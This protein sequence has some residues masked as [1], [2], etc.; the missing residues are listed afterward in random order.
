M[1]KFRP[2]KN[3]LLCGGRFFNQLRFLFFI[4]FALL[5]SILFFQVVFFNPHYNYAPLAVVCFAL[6]W[7]FV[8]FLLYRLTQ[9]FKNRIE[10]HEK[11]LL[12]GFG[13]L[14][15]LTQIFFYWQLAVYPTN[16]Y[17]RVFTGAVNFSVNGFI[18]EPYLDYFYKYPNN[19]PL[20][21]V[22]Q[23][24]F[25]IAN[26]LGFTNFYL[27]GVVFNAVCIH[28]T[29]VFVY[30]CCR[31]TCGISRGFFALLLLYFC[32][33]IQCHIGVFYTDTITMPFA[34]FAMYM[35]LRLLKDGSWKGHLLAA[36][37]LGLGMALGTKLKYSV[38][39]VLVAILLDLLIRLKIK[40]LLALVISFLICFAAVNYGFNRFMYSNFLDE[41]LAKDRSTPFTSWIMMGLNGDGSHNPNDNYLI[42]NLPTKEEKQQKAKEELQNRFTSYSPLE[43]LAFLNQKALYSFGSGNLDYGRNV[44]DSPRAQT[45]LVECISP[46]GRYFTA[47]DTFVQ[48]YHVALFFLVIAGAVLAAKQRSVLLFAPYLA[49]FG[50]FLFLL[51]WESGQRYLFNFYGLCIL[52]ATS[53]ST[54]FGRIPFLKPKIHT[55]KTTYTAEKP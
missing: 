40:H 7:L 19:M 6:F 2:G 49:I 18:E 27:I 42:W 26:R 11:L 53:G 22:L 5:F 15:L 37:L 24:L 21:I 46:G 48:G 12:L 54:L 39:I 9:H 55:T 8:F 30:L 1:N 44:G 3:G 35:Y 17:E 4:V 50:L 20:T 52:T 13:V 51:L 31:C 38:V 29:Y 16:D 36:V 47:F 43:F 10:R 23:F 14:L 34:A 32:L 28:L 33:A 25:R 45:V 41:T